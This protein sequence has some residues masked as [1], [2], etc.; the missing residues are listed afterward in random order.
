MR[1]NDDE[2]SSNGV[3]VS[4]QDNMVDIAK[5]T[6]NPRDQV[7][8][9]SQQINPRVASRIGLDD[10]NRLVGILL[11][12]GRTKGNYEKVWEEGHSVDPPH[13]HEVTEATSV[14]WFRYGI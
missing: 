8:A 2:I 7:V 4:Y 12:L 3:P 14:L 5:T 9:A 6:P 1:H 10:L 13:S 11:R